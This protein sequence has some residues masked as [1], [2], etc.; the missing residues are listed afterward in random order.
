MESRPF[1]GKCQSTW[2]QR[3]LQQPGRIDKY[4]RLPAAIARMEMRRG[5]VI[6]IHLDND[7]EESRDFHAA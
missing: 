2:R 5:M 1:Q 7:S 4:P 3:A 6:E